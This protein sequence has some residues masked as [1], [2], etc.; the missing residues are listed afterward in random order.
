MKLAVLAVTLL[1]GSGI[2]HADRDPFASPA[3]VDPYADPVDPYTDAAP[4]DPF[5]QRTGPWQK[6]AKRARLRQ[7]LVQRFDQNGD[8]RLQPNERKQAARA[9]KKLAHR[10]QQQGR[11]HGP[12]RRERLIQRFDLNGDGNLGP[13]EVPPRVKNRLRNVDRNDDGWIGTD[14]LP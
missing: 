4:V 14:E 7:A 5:A 12:S 13:G 2:A 11:Q 8:G 3:P 10:L 9:L 1:F 6:K